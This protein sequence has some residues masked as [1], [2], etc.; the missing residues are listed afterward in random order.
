M[1]TLAK[2]IAGAKSSNIYDEVSYTKTTLFQSLN[3]DSISMNTVEKPSDID[4][5]SLQAG[6]MNVIDIKNIKYVESTLSYVEGQNPSSY[7]RVWASLND[8]QAQYYYLLTSYQLAGLLASFVAVL[9]V[10]MAVC[11]TIDLQAPKVFARSKL[12]YGKVQE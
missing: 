12:E 9:I 2:E 1:R 3:S 6:A 7:G 11:L 8:G 10:L 4:A 5:I